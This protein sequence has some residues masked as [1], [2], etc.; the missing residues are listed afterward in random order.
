MV[1]FPF[2]WLSI[3]ACPVIRKSIRESINKNTE[4]RETLAMNALTSIYCDELEKVNNLGLPSLSAEAS[5]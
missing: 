5:P 1:L 2:W 4:Q 3:L